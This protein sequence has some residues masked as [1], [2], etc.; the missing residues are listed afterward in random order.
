MTTGSEPIRAT[1]LQHERHREIVRIAHEAGAVDVSSLAVSFDV[2]NETIRRDLSELQDR[3]L[4]RR[5]HG[6]AVPVERNFHEPMVQARDTR[7]ADE[8]L[9]IAKEAAHEV[10]D[11]GSIIIDSGSTSL[12]FAEVFPVDRNA[13]VV[14]N[15]LAIGMTL[16][17]RGV[18]DLTVLG[19]EVRTNTF[20]MVDASAVATVRQLRV[21][22]LFI[23]CDGLSLD[24]GLTTPYREEFL[25]KRAMIDAARRVVAIIDHSK[26]GNDQLFACCA[27]S[28]IDL[29]ITDKRADDK[30]VATIEQHGVEVRRV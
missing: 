17:R 15:S 6:G 30:D 5:V 28:E 1:W 21:D 7:N 2:T 19:G 16:A 18:T 9:R 11:H 14:T 10:P 4:L 26:F 12:R 22:V 25:I 13:Q 23:S 3:Q 8:K 29:V 27:L 24:R 20:A